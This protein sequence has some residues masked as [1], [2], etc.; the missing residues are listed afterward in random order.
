MEKG[1]NG[2]DDFE[3]CPVLAEVARSRRIVG[4]NGKVFEQLAA[5]SSRNNLLT[6]RRLMLTLN[7]E[8]TLEIGLGFGGSTLMFASTHRDLRHAPCGQHTSID[9]FQ[10]TVWDSSAILLLERT[11]FANVDLVVSP[12]EF[13]FG[14]PENAA[15]E[16][17]V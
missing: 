6:L 16:R 5:L 9:P 12:E 14:T 1:H 11:D 13:S 17:T 10:T 2:D 7:P 4:N 3:F 8:R 15:T